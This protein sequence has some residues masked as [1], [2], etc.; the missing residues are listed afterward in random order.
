MVNY[1]CERCNKTFNHKSNY[2]Q[3]LNRSKPCTKINNTLE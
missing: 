2:D 3:H 1:T